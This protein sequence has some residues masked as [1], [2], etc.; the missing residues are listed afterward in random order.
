M[1]SLKIVKNSFLHGALLVR[2]WVYSVTRK[3]NQTE[4]EKDGKQDK[5]KRKCFIENEKKNEISNIDYW[6]YHS[7]NRM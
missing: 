6:N 4:K 7:F 3:V 5:E 1:F 2:L